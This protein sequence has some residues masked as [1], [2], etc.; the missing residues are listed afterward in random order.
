MLYRHLQD[1]GWCIIFRMV[2]GRVFMLMEGSIGFRLHITYYFSRTD[3]FLF[4]SA[5][6]QTPP[7][8]TND[9]QISKK[10][11]VGQDILT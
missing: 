10:I 6:G 3:S 2:N 5:Q 8:T 4:I 7:Q 1:G 9:G 11:P